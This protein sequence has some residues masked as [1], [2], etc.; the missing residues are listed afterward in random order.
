MGHLV[1]D[2]HV[3]L[4]GGEVETEK[5]LPASL[6]RDTFWMVSDHWGGRLHVT[7]CDGGIGSGS[8]GRNTGRESLEP[9]KS[10]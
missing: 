7:R 1:T 3:L 4:G 8:R 2:H 10:I 5:L 6:S 9:L